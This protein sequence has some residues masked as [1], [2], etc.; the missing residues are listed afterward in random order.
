MRAHLPRSPRWPLLATILATLTTLLADTTTAATFDASTGSA[1]NLATFTLTNIARA[2]FPYYAANI[3]R[4]AGA[5]TSCAASTPRR[6]TLEWNTALAAA[7]SY[8][9]G[10]M[11]RSRCFSHNDCN[12]SGE[13]CSFAARLRRFYQ[14]PGAS[15]NIAA[16]AQDP[17]E[18]LVGREVPVLK[19]PRSLIPLISLTPLTDSTDL[20]V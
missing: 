3:A 12:C 1:D 20:T 17:V 6:T 9:T 18:L 2:N 16:G 11:M 14:G 8:H 5:K 4:S 13:Q 15:E 7:A 10:D 19:D